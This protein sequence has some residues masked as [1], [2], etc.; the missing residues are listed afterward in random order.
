VDKELY[1]FLVARPD[2]LNSKLPASL[3]LIAPLAISNATSGAR[4]KEF[5]EVMNYDNMQLAFNQ[6]SQY[7]AAGT[8]WMLDTFM[9]LSS[10]VLSPTQL[11]SANWVWSEE[12]F[13]LS[14]SKPSARRFSFD[15][16]L[17]A[18]IEDA[19]NVQR[20]SEG[21][22]DVVMGTALPILAGRAIVISW[23][24]AMAAALQ[25]PDKEERL[26]RLFEAAMSVPI[27]LRLAPD[28]DACHLAVFIFRKICLLRRQPRT[29]NHFV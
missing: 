10:D 8:I 21:S 1:T 14:S 20:T 19:S 6:S 9:A 26:F 27:R 29:R 16:P 22:T 23:Y 24:G 7:E 12:A 2:K 5:R 13:L 25:D 17:P 11:E 18:R 28:D 4:L 3:M 15:V